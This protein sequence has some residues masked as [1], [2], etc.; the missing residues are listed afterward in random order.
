LIPT[1]VKPPAPLPLDTE[2][3]ELE[4]DKRVIIIFSKKDEK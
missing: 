1:A 3:L 2:S 4:I